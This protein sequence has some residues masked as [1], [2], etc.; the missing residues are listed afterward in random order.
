M[1]LKEWHE[2]VEAYMKIPPAGFDGEAHTG[3]LARK[4]PITITDKY[5]ELNGKRNEN[6]L[7]MKEPY[8]FVNGP[9][10]P[11]KESFFD[12]P[13]APSK[14]ELIPYK[15]KERLKKADVMKE[16]QEL[17]Q[18]GR[19]AKKI[20]YNI[21]KEEY[22]REI[23]FR[24]LNDEQKFSKDG[25]HPV[26]TPKIL[27]NLRY[28][29]GKSPESKRL[30]D[31]MREEDG[32]NN[33]NSGNPIKKGKFDGFNSGKKIR[34]YGEEDDEEEAKQSQTEVIGFKNGKLQLI[35]QDPQN[36]DSKSKGIL[37]N[38]GKGKKKKTVKFKLVDKF[39]RKQIPHENHKNIIFRQGHTEEDNQSERT[40]QSETHIPG[41]DES[42]NP[43]NPNHYFKNTNATQIVLQNSPDG[44]DLE[45][46]ILKVLRGTKQTKLLRF[47]CQTD[48]HDSFLVKELKKRGWLCTATV[49]KIN[50]TRIL[51]L[52]WVK[53][54]LHAEFHQL[55][56][57]QY[58]NKIEGMSIL[59][60]QMK[61]YT[62]L[63]E[64]KKEY[65]EK[66][67]YAMPK[68]FY[69][70]KKNQIDDFKREY[71]FNMMVVVVKKHIRY[72]EQILGPQNMARLENRF[73]MEKEIEQE[74]HT[75]VK[76][77]IFT[78][79]MESKK[80]KKMKKER[81][82]LILETNH[83][84][85][86]ITNIYLLCHCLNL[87]W[88]FIQQLAD[89]ETDSTIFLLEDYDKKVLKY[90]YQFSL[91][92]PPYHKVSM[93]KRKEIS[94]EPKVLNNWRTPNP[95]L[96]YRV[97]QIHKILR[98]SQFKMTDFYAHC[99]L[100]NT[101]IVKKYIT[102]AEQDAINNPKLKVKKETISGFKNPELQ[103]IYS[104][105][106]LKDKK[107]RGRSKSK[108][109]KNKAQFSSTNR[110]SKSVSAS[111]NPGK[112]VNKQILVSN[113]LPEILK[114]F[115][116][117]PSDTVSIQKY[118]ENPILYELIDF[119]QVGRESNKIKK[120][121]YKVDFRQ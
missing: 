35:L 33:M 28:D 12:Y 38:K 99:G 16:I 94:M 79:Y 27:E 57:S 56:T 119:S 121:N 21:E 117:K 25:Y 93:A 66:L 90:I 118:V 37:M 32:Q 107:K 72:F 111:I 110:S 71:F 83:K 82:T 17:D 104:K 6:S 50:Q 4:S 8:K 47:I 39:G 77:K 103:K 89:L 108:G 44:I 53:T 26:H 81:K 86:F 75:Y 84:G 10:L 1:S 70:N 13:N 76:E 116:D 22:E 65:Y 60:S 45:K 102:Q 58:I 64:E 95:D 67:E 61:Y 18:R 14:N 49:R 98:D 29:G 3:F 68:T 34:D 106:K 78:A 101:W 69:M 97:Y 80:V 115:G 24:A 9:H 11:F 100:Q 5:L 85:L 20:L 114:F 55:T 43:N 63:K 88:S 36:K 2:K 51:N 15:I 41:D 48:F 120:A 109:K 42:F 46:E 92:N 113:D 73:Q 112:I 105:K 52:K 7:I 54:D 96:V 19:E 74:Y 91:L 59:T 62:I 31:D 40:I 23:N 87:I 30:D